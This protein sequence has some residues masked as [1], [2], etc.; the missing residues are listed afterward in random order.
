MHPI[1][2]RIPLPNRPLK[3][4]WALVAVAAIAAIYGL[5]SR[6]RNEKSDAMTGL[7]VSA[8]AGFGAWYFRASEFKAENIPIY[9]YGVMLGLSLVVGWYITLPLAAKD[10]LDKETMANCY[11]ITALAALV[12]SRLLYIV[13]NPGQF[14]TLSDWFALRRGGLVA[15][16]GFLGGFLGSWAYLRAKGV[17]LLPWADVAVPS[18]ASGLLITRIGCYLFGC[19]FGTRLS[20]GAPG[21]LRKLGTFPHLP[22]G[23]LGY[24]D[25][26]NPI[27]GS[28]AFAH[29]LA[30]Y[31]SC[32]SN[33]ELNCVDPGDHSFPVHPTQLYEAVI[34]LGLLAFLLWARRHQKFRGQ[35]FFLFA[36]A[37]GFLRF[38][39]EL[40]RDDLERGDVPPRMDKYLLVGFALFLFAIA[41]TFGPS[42]SIPD[43]RTRTIAR[44]FA[45]VPVPIALWTLRTGQFV[46]DPYNLSTSQFIGLLTALVVAYFYAKLWEQARKNPKAAMAVVDLSERALKAEAKR[47]KRDDDEDERP[48]S[49]T[50]GKPAPVTAKKKPAPVPADVEDEDEDEDDDE[51]DDD[52]PTA[53]APPVKPS[54]KDEDEDDDDADEEED[55]DDDEDASPVPA[56]SKSKD[57][58]EDDDEDED[59]EPSKA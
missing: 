50:K 15:Y 7:V 35:I 44:A 2:F 46:S 30:Q 12:G 3:L 59:G 26:G 43:P 9:S 36:F 48:K 6:S 10:G 56:K 33:G 41:F 55:E 21:F 52:A 8:A 14:D 19:D 40:W 37:Y 45:F 27:I 54:S 49:K 20:D 24:D 29:H 31:Q 4:W 25:K 42:L 11:V 53:K 16:G 18:L 34:G 51:A 32:R 47:K 38:I 28:P 22:D 57:A 17:R 39:L 5:W 58:D 13:T 1:L 23:T